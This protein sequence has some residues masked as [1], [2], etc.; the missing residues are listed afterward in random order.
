MTFLVV[1]NVIFSVFIHFVIHSYIGKTLQRIIIDYAFSF[2]NRLIRYQLLACFQGV[3]KI[4]G[5]RGIFL[6]DQGPEGHI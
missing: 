5:D 4:T 3:R 1:L 2:Q 6:V